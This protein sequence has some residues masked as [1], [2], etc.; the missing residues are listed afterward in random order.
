MLGC[1][2][3]HDLYLYDGFQQVQHDEVSLCGQVSADKSLL[4]QLCFGPNGIRWL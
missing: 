3:L 4:V 2:V 1:K